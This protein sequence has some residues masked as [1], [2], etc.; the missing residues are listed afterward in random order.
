V[1]V[2]AELLMHEVREVFPNCLVVRDGF[3][4]SILA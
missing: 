2:G 4:K 1:R 3:F